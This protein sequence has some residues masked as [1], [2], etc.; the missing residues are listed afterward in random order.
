MKCADV[1]SKNLEWLT[2]KD[3]V[4]RAATVMVE[5]GV[6]F[7]PIC[8]EG[9]RVVGVVTDRDL[10]TRAIAQRVAP[11]TTSA[12][13]VMSAPPVTCLASTDVREAEELMVRERKA[14]LVITDDAGGLIGVLS[15][16]DLIEH[17]P[18][19]ASIATVRAVLWRE[20]L[21]PRAGAPKGQPLLKDDPIAQ[22]QPTPADDAEARP[23]VFTGGH[24]DVDTR[25]FPG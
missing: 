4:L 22:N 23:T 7:L 13:L 20:A 6:G 10:A 21:G 11:E 8:G 24:R 16:A 1:M 3:T 14:R 5:A 19:R 17:A 2:E 12:T 25:E 9:R 15:L 18:K